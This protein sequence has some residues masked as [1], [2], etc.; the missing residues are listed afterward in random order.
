MADCILPL[1]RRISDPECKFFINKSILQSHDTSLNKDNCCLVAREKLH[2]QNWCW[3]IPHSVKQKCQNT[4][5]HI[6]RWK[7]EKGKKPKKFREQKRE[8]KVQNKNR[9]AT[10]RQ[11]MEYPL[12]RFGLTKEHWNWWSKEGRI[13]QQRNDFFLPYQ[14]YHACKEKELSEELKEWDNKIKNMKK[15]NKTS[16]AVFLMNASLLWCHSAKYNFVTFLMKIDQVFT[17]HTFENW[18]VYF[19]SFVEF[20]QK[21][22]ISFLYLHFTWFTELEAYYFNM[23]SL[24][25]IKIKRSIVCVDYI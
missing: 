3:R 20:L 8:L 13:Y 25:M 1:P 18:L 16:A 22:P 23:S 5:Y 12:Q 17:F 7:D 4:L 2:W 9:A 11:E 14:N 24:Q 15:M 19:F 21:C 6:F 10:A